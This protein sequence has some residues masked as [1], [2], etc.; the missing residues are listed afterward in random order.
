MKNLAKLLIVKTKRAE[1]FLK[2]C[3]K[4]IAVTAFEFQY[5]F[6]SIHNVAMPTRSRSGVRYPDD[7]GI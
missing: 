4:A 6:E 5:G 2:K 1:S 3:V 7:Y